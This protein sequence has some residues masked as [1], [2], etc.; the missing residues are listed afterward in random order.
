M[1]KLVKL[2]VA[3]LTLI[4]IGLYMTMPVMV[5]ANQI[6]DDRLL[7]NYAESLISGNWLGIY[8]YLTLV[9]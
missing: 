1:K 7:F 6:H 4:R 8:N 5:Y 2:A 3:F 9:K